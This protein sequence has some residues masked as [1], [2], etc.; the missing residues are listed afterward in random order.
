[1]SDLGFIA[2]AYGLIWLLVAVYVF[3]IAGRQATLRRHVEQLQME[4][5]EVAPKVG[6][7]RSQAA[8]VAGTAASSASAAGAVDSR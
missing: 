7:P 6:M 1:M 2:L 4:V 8:S 5:E 3:F